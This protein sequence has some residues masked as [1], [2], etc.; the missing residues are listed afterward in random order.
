MLLER[1]HR[2]PPEVW[3]TR[4]RTALASPWHHAFR[5]QLLAVPPLPLLPAGPLQ[6]PHARWPRCSAPLAGSLSCSASAAC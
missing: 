3:E 5:A 1:T 6:P 4:A 2:F